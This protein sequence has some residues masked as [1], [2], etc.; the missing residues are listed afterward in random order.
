MKTITPLLITNKS[1]VPFEVWEA[2][3][4]YTNQMDEFRK[5]INEINLWSN[6]F[7]RKISTIKKLKKNQK[8]KTTHY[9]LDLR[10]IIEYIF[11]APLLING[12]N[13]NSKIRKM[14]STKYKKDDFLKE[15][16]KINKNYFPRKQIMLD[17][18]GLYFTDSYK[19]NEILK[20]I[21]LDLYNKLS[22]I[23]HHNQF[24]H[25]K[26]E[27]YKYYIN[28]LF[29]LKDTTIFI[30]VFLGSHILH[31]FKTDY[32]F[33]IFLL[34]N[35]TQSFLFKTKES[36]FTNSELQIV[37]YIPDPINFS[38]SN[39]IEIENISKKDI[40]KEHKKDIEEWSEIKGSISSVREIFN[41][42]DQEQ[43]RT[44]KTCFDSKIN[45]FS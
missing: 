6:S 2:M 41:N 14:S 20:D 17:E 31:L 8:R 27:E 9:S 29:D 44:R 43:K 38:K 33:W 21:T 12:K 7:L 39:K 23:I 10:R 26:Q 19:F 15:I 37:C 32:Y 34:D 13:Y 1:E 28:A 5:I 22:N 35:K 3:E 4:T 25:N 42:Q 30:E 36:L 45:N 11:F 40:E 18:Q 16:E 24:F